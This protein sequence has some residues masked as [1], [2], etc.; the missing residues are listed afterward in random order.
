MNFFRRTPQDATVE[1]AR[2]DV[3][4]KQG[5]RDANSGLAEHDGALRH[6]YERGRRDE[7]ARHTRRRSHPILGS[8]LVLAAAAGAFVIYLGVRQGSFAGGGEVVDQNIHNAIAP[9]QQAGRNAADRAGDAL[10]NAGQKLKQTGG[11][12]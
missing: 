6:A 10:Q 3:A 8:V 1:A 4:Y 11:N 12:G 7:R 2:G 9:A 5:L